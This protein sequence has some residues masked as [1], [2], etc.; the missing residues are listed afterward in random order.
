MLRV[1]IGA[2]E[3]KEN[4]VTVVAAVKLSRKPCIHYNVS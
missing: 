4:R 1:H 3:T 2:G